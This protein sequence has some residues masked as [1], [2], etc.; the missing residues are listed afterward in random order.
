MQLFVEH[1]AKTLPKYATLQPLFLLSPEDPDVNTINKLTEKHN[2]FYYDNE[3]LGRKKNAGLTYA[4]NYEWDYYMDMGSDDVWTDMLWKLYEPFFEDR[5]PYF[6]INNTYQYDWMNDRASFIPGWHRNIHNQDEVT[7]LGV[8][9][10]IIRELVEKAH[11]AKDDRGNT[12]LWREK[13][14]RGM[15]G[16]SD[17]KIQ[18][19][20]YKAEVIDVQR[21]PV[22]FRG[23]QILQGCLLS[24]PRSPV[25]GV[26]MQ[27]MY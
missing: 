14:G 24:I 18:K 26:L 20:G 25:P 4:L 8:G 3:P 21:M 19:Q 6:G 22:V 2:R 11:R 10:C 17:Y 13:W 5:V 9:R 12:G 23:A 1:M 7:A 15:D 16:I 27:I